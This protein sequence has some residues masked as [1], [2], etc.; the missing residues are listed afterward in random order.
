MP[1]GYRVGPGMLCRAGQ[2]F[3]TLGGVLEMP[4]ADL[5]Q[6]LLLPW[7]SAGI[8]PAIGKTL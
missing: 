8:H 2:W 1:A 4:L 5:P 6:A 3:Q 7:P